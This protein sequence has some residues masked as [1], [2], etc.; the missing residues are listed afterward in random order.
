MAMDR[1]DREREMA[2]TLLADLAQA[3]VVSEEQVGLGF[4]KL[5]SS[6]EDLTLDIPDA[7]SM[8][9]FFL[10]RAIVDEVMCPS[11]LAHADAKLE[12]GSLGVDICVAAK[13]LLAAKHSAER[14]ATCWHGYFLNETSEALSSAFVTMIKEYVISKNLKELLKC[15]KDVGMPH[16]HHELVYQCIVVALDDRSAGETVFELLAKLFMCG[17]INMT[18]T[19]I[20]YNRL[21]ADK[22]DLQL[23]YH[24]APEL[25]E[26]T[27][28]IFRLFKMI[29]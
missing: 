8:L 1:G 13:K 7:P 15:L 28:T 4:S 21:C 20:A 2:S 29:E 3:G 9:T 14:F 6:A 12:A 24:G 19:T 11:F 5:L 26:V 10:G 16:Y 22:E 25:I 18:Q 17:E 27:G 23:D